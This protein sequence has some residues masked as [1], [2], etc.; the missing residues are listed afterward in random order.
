MPRAP[1]RRRH[2]ID[3]ASARGVVSVMASELLLYGNRDGAA[4]GRARRRAFLIINDK[5]RDE[6]QLRR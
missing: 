3:F 4:A 6:A 1:E 5:V 2:A